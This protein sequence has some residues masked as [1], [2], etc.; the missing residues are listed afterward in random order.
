MKKRTGERLEIASAKANLWKKVREGGED[1]S[2]RE[3]TA[4]EGVRTSVM[5]LEEDGR[6][7]NQDEEDE[8]LGCVTFVMNRGEL[9]GGK[10]RDEGKVK[11]DAR[12]RDEMGD[13]VQAGRVLEGVQGQHG[14]R[15]NPMENE[16][17][18]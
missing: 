9:L 10:V 12:E 8:K 2:E 5:L 17:N 4:W 14:G 18:A 13:R 6:W 15:G 1:L 3:V 16:K 11:G 7:R